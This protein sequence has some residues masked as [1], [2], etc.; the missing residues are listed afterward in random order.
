M[1]IIELNVSKREKTGKGAGRELRRTGMIPAILYGRNREPEMLT[2]K[3]KDFEDAVR[4]KQIGRLMFQLNIQN[5][6]A[7][8][9]RVMIK[10]LQ[11]DPVRFDFIHIDF[12]EVSMDRKINVRIPVTTR[13]KCIGVEYG[14]TL[15]LI[16]RELE[17]LCFPMEIPDQIEI[18][19]TNLNV[20]DVV[21]VKDIETEG[22]I[23]IPAEVN[24]TVLTVVG[25]KP[26]EAELEEEEAEEEEA[27]EGAAEASGE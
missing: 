20:G 9:K 17:V 6:T 21:H 5:G 7:D 12:Y 16:R 19:V 2:V 18:D 22:D 25:A 1:E 13:G 24:F 3:L 26:T 4:S 10:E 11:R 8:A 14:G 15:Q 23:E 27:E